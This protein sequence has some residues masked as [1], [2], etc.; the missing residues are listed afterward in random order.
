MSYG[1]P[2]DKSKCLS[3]YFKCFLLFQGVLLFSGFSR[4]LLRANPVL[5]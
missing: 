2:T 5:N 4:K 3:Y 1:T